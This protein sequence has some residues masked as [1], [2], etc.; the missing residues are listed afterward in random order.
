[1]ISYLILSLLLTEMSALRYSIARNVLH[2]NVLDT[3]SVLNAESNIYTSICCTFWSKVSLQNS[4]YYF[5][6]QPHLIHEIAIIQNTHPVYAYNLL[7]CI[8]N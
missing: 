3:K 4:G 7:A 5:I 2:I 6:G 8:A 1:M